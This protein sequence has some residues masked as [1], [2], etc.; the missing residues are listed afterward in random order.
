VASFEHSFTVRAPAAAVS[1][2]HHDTR[3]LRRLTPPPIFVQLRH[4]EPLAEGSVSRFTLWFGPLPVP[5]TAV[6]S[7]VSERGFTDTLANGLLKRWV[8]THRFTPQGPR[9]T[10]VTEQIEYEHRSGWRGLLSHLLFAPPGLRFLFGYRSWVTR[11][12][13]EQA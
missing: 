6:H 8:H 5:W 1:A 13:L 10:R 2:F 7:G 3:A 12:A 9:A 4:V 11:R